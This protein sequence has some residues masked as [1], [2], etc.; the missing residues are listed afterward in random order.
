MDADWA[1]G[2]N[3]IIANVL[4]P[5]IKQIA[6]DYSLILVDQYSNVDPPPGTGWDLIYGSGD[7]LHLS[8]AG[9]I[10]VAEGWLTQILDQP[11]FPPGVVSYWKLDEGTGP[12]YLDSRN[13]NNG[14]SS[15]N[16]PTS[17]TGLVDGA[18]HF[19]GND[20]INVAPD[21]T[22]DWEQGDSF[23]L[24]FWMRKNALASANEVI[25]GRDDNDG[26]SPNYL[27]WWVGVG[28]SSNPGKAIFYLR[29]TAGTLFSVAGTT[30]V[31][32]GLWHHVVAVRDAVTSE[33][34]IYVDGVLE[35][36]TNAIYNAG[37]IAPTT[38]M[39][40][41]GMEIGTK[42]Y[43]FIGDLDEAAMYSRALTSDQIQ[44]HYID[45]STGN[46]YFTDKEYAPQ[47]TSSPDSNVILNTIYQYNVEATGNPAPTYTLD[48]GPSNMYIN[49]ATGLLQWT[50]DTTDTCFVTVSV[51]NAL[52]SDS[53]SFTLKAIDHALLLSTFPDRSGAIT[54]DTCHCFRRYF[55]FHW[56]R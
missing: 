26:P 41:G 54:L 21:S 31:N 28:Y 39:T 51:H 44:N 45:G 24:E 38:K 56:P 12:T 19:D 34:R 8:D 7:G 5:K 42:A 18:Q 46:S 2:K 32:D 15:Y 30:I 14:Q 29:D 6:I 4:N 37:F 10:K 11:S 40:I 33:L 27:H 22:F 43:N 3:D 47:I 1:I 17:I 25:M 35:G 52:G 55:C 50:V 23:S 36:T 16:Y 49:Q 20:I 48:S 53:Q 13:V 9:E